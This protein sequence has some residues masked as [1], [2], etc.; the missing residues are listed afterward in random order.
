MDAIWHPI[1]LTLV[2]R[3]REYIIV[4]RGNMYCLFIVDVFRYD[5]QLFRRT[6]MH[7]YRVQEYMVV[8]GENYFSFMDTNG[9]YLASN[10]FATLFL[11]TRI[12]H[13]RREN[14]Y[15]ICTSEV[16]IK[17]SNYFA[18]RLSS[19]SVVVE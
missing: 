16:S 1:T 3:I 12:H 4:E 13:K 8:K 14:K 10:Y 17:I 5:I 11:I 15:V 7:F 6:F 9:C 2:Y 19:T 18:E